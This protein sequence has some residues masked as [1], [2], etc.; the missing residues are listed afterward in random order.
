MHR[1]AKVLL[2]KRKN[3]PNEGRWALPGGLVELGETTQDAAAREVLE[4]TGL[5]VGIEGLLDVQ[6]DLH[7]D[8][9][10][11][12]E[13]HYVLIDYLAKPAGGRLKI[14]QESSASGWFSE[15]QTRSLPMSG[16]TRAV[17][18]LFF[19]QRRR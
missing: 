3:P 14:N 16:G 15:R 12:L 18:G 4:E 1:G 17:L 10:S 6:T 8:G 7:F 5:K 13:Y 11:R 19:R 9:A 2:V